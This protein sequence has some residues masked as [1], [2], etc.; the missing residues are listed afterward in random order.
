M[1]LDYNSISNEIICALEN[2]QGIV[3]ATSSDDK[4]TART[5]SHVNDGLYIMFQT[6]GNS[7]KAM[8]MR[9]N[10]RVAF[11]LDNIQ[12]E[13]IAELCGHPKENQ[14]FIKKYRAKYPNCY[15]KY[16]DLPYEILVTAKPKKITLYK[17]IEGK[18]CKDILIVDENKALREY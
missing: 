9:T 10:Q 14:L 13:A 1:F 4:V 3:L 8:Q 18:P 7:E 12:I 16:T 11:A 15:T 6:D 2:A 17:Y 5:M